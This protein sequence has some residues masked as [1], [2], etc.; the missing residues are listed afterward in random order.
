MTNET[1]DIDALVRQ[2]SE[3][4]IEVSKNSDG[5]LTVCSTAE[6]LFCYD[7]HTPEE[8]D[9]LV[10]DTILSYAKHFFHIEGLNLKTKSEPLPET[11]VQ[12]ERGTPVSRITPV[13]DLAA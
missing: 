9:A 12:I 5:L 1:R 3:L 2:L 6:P 7:A 13:F 4:K 8:V 11:P 10:Q